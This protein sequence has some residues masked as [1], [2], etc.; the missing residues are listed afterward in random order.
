MFVAIKTICF[1]ITFIDDMAV[2]FVELTLMH[3]SDRV[4]SIFANS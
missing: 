1:E 2:I 4:Y 3:Y